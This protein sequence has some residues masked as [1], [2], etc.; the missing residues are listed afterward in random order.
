M[1]AM[2]QP[3]N[4]PLAA[5]PRKDLRLPHFKE[6]CPQAWFNRVEAYF[7]IHDKTDSEL[8]F[9]YVLWALSPLQEKLVL[10]I[11]SLDY[12]LPNAYGLLKES[13]LQLYEKGECSLG[14]K[15]LELPPIGGLDPS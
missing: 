9:Y 2:T 3:I 13:L 15:L 10:E 4:N 6:A 12:P 7:R 1:L 11:T 5:A 8:W 14:R